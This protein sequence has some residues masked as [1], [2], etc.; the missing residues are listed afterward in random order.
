MPNR[1]ALALSFSY[2][3]KVLNGKVFHP[4]YLYK[5]GGIKTKENYLREAW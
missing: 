2:T 1:G 5:V 4:I 3:W